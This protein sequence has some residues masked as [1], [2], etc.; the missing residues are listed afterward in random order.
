MK[1]LK[2][3]KFKIIIKINS[4]DTIILTKKNDNKNDKFKKEKND[5]K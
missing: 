4:N 5:E 3:I 1:K 2:Q